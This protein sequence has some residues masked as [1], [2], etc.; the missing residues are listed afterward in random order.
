MYGVWRVDIVV[1]GSLEKA[2]ASEALAYFSMGG[3]HGISHMDSVMDDGTLFGARDDHVGGKPPGL[4][5]RPPGYATFI[6]RVVAHIPGTIL[7]QQGYWA[8]LDSQEH[9]PYDEMDIWRFAENKDAN[10]NGQWF[11]NA[12]VIT[13]LQSVDLLR[14]PLYLAPQKLTPVAAMVL[15]T[16][17]AGVTWQECD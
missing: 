10:P 6:R 5:K 13:A 14:S 9:K 17:I 2:L 1:Q 11:C 15:I 8:F 16:S 7:Q 12:V 4:E 3:T